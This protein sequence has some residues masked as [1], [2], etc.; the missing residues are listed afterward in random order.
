MN[1]W[2]NDVN[3]KSTKQLFHTGCVRWKVGPTGFTF[4]VI[5]A[6]LDVRATMKWNKELTLRRNEHACDCV[7]TTGQDGLPRHLLAR[8]TN[9]SLSEWF[10][11]FPKSCRFFTHSPEEKKWRAYRKT[12]ALLPHHTHTHR[13]RTENWWKNK[14][15]LTFCPWP[16]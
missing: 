13:K 7:G 9:I 5:Y 16:E 1:G 3:K 10:F 8:V 6:R 4:V 14:H 15:H 11:Q 12:F 2:I